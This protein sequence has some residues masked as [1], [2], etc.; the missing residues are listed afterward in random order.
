M[1]LVAVDREVWQNQQKPSLVV[2][3]GSGPVYNAG[4]SDPFRG[5]H[6]QFFINQ[7]TIVVQKVWQ[8]APY[9]PTG[10][11]VDVTWG[12]QNAKWFDPAASWTNEYK[13]SPRTTTDFIQSSDIY[14]GHD[15]YG[16][17]EDPAPPFWVNENRGTKL[18]RDNFNPYV[19]ANDVWLLK[20]QDKWMEPAAVW[21]TPQPF[22]SQ[23]ISNPYVP[24]LATLQRPS[25]KVQNETN[26]GFVDFSQRYPPNVIFNFK[27]YDPTVDPTRLRPSDKF[28]QE[29]Q[30]IW[31]TWPLT[32][33]V[34]IYLT[35]PYNPAADPTRFVKSARFDAVLNDLF[36]NPSR[37]TRVAWDVSQI[38]PPPPSFLTV[39]QNWGG[40]VVLSPKKL[41]E[42]VFVPVDFIS[43]LAANETIVTA[44]C[45][46]TVYSGID[47][48]PSSMLIGPAGI[49]GTV[50]EQE[51]GGGVLGT[52]YEL[53]FT[54][55]TSLGQTLELS[56]YFAVEPDLP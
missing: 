30:V 39:V 56:G 46:C 15:T 32:Q 27:P 51:V 40:R 43:R 34:L 23:A 22:L 35:P 38:I 54:I 31:N 37:G 7:E 10:F 1:A 2:V 48:S 55:T 45:N 24:Y 4:A 41:G 49:N 53:L 26:P 33:N 44:T 12:R 28:F 50:V 36:D 47:P 29:P 3:V 11:F 14:A 21:F 42:S 20:K 16:W 5:H 9:G 13:P 18:V 8:T 19:P 52:I 25:D 6:A 17:P